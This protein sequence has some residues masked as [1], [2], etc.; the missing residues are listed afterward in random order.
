VKAYIAAPNF[1]GALS[2]LLNRL[3]SVHEIP[4][5]TLATILN[6]SCSPSI[7]VAADEDDLEVTSVNFKVIALHDIRARLAYDAEGVRDLSTLFGSDET[8]TSH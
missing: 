4:E 3:W 5:E 8:D 1:T 6:L 7:T 2:K